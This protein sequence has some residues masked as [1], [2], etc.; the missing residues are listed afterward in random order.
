M[1][2][3]NLFYESEE[4]QRV[5]DLVTLLSISVRVWAKNEINTINNE[6]ICNFMNEGFLQIVF[7]SG[8]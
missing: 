2:Y 5:N 3:P 7:F 4:K 6:C 1:E 8:F